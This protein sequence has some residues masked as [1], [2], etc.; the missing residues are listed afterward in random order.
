MSKAITRLFDVLWG[1]IILLWIIVLVDPSTR[2][3]YMS[4]TGAHEYLG[5]FFNFAILATMGDL[6]AGRIG[7][8]KWTI[9]VATIFKLLIWGFIGMAITLFFGLGA[10]GV[11][12]LQKAHM[13]PFAG[14]GFG[15]NFAH[16]LFT[17]ILLNVSFGPAMFIF[18][19]FTDTYINAKFNK[20]PANMDALIESIDWKTFFKFTVLTTLPCFWIPC[21]TIVFLL[22][23][24]YRV[25]MAAF[26]SIALGLLL[27]IKNKVSAKAN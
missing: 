1:L 7:T 16:A 18:H 25:L 8:K 13:L 10:N 4:I 22:P 21:H 5:G 2:G 20:T 17:S 24:D 14:T 19:K 6:L 11:A 9:N 26:L 23:A 3:V 12:D 15:S 27:S